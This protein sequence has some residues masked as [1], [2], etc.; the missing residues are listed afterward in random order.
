MNS[1]IGPACGRREVTASAF[2][3]SKQRWPHIFGSLSADDELR[4]SE[5]M[6]A[7][8]PVLIKGYESMIMVGQQ[9]M[10]PSGWCIPEVGAA[11][12]SPEHE[13]V[14]KR[15]NQMTVHWGGHRVCGHC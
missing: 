8:R 1:T 15:A 6:R 2:T 12:G 14:S 13:Q 9:A 4:I 5:G 11:P 7:V 10:K 3:A